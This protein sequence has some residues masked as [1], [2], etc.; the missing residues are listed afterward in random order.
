MAEINTDQYDKAARYAVGHGYELRVKP[1]TS[2]VCHSTSNPT[3]KNTAFSAEAEF[4]YESPLVS[5]H[6][7]IGKDGRVVRFLDPRLYVAWHAGN[8]RTEW[9]NAKSI[10]IEL[11]HSVGDP[12]YPNMQL[13]ALAGLLGFL[14]EFFG[15]ALDTIETHG[16]IALPGPYKRKSDPSDWPHADF[17]RWRNGLGGVSLPQPPPIT[18]RYRAKRIMISQRPECGLPY[19]GELQPGEEVTVDK[20]YAAHH[21]VHLQD[22]RGFVLLEDLEAL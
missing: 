14:M 2:I 1:V 7:V 21:S 13:D 19:A 9:A 3:H 4:L 17:I 16:Q 12:P 20:W 8:A 5:A 11:H 15:I 10:G 22:Q 18:K 6:Y